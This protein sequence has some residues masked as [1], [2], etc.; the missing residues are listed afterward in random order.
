VLTLAI[1]AGGESR[2]M[3]SDKALLPFLGEPLILRVLNRLADISDEILVTSNQPESY[4]FLGLTPI[5]DVVPGIGALGGLYTALSAAG[6]PYVA[7]VAC[8]M[9]FASPE[10]FLHELLLLRESGADAVVPR[11]E[12]GTEPF[13]AVYRAETCLPFVQLVVESGKR[14]ADAWFNQVNIR[15]MNPGEIHPYD[16]DNLAF[17]NINTPE[18]LEDAEELAR[19]EIS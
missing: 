10:L 6:H 3:G 15:Y 14:R 2:R 5:A 7:V 1:Q 4:R 11:W 19:E 18:E 16:P 13:H 17:L 12:G 8:D 9:P